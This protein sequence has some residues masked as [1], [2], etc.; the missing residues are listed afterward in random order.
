V[1]SAKQSENPIAVKCG[2]GRRG[3]QKA[4]SAVGLITASVHVANRAALFMQL[5]TRKQGPVGLVSGAQVPRKQG[6]AAPLV[7]LLFTFLH[8]TGMCPNNQDS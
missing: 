4:S 1:T 3:D 5:L 8:E 2:L 6:L 7:L